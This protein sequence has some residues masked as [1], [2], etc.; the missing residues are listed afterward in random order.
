MKKF[1]VILALILSVN[2]IALATFSDMPENKMYKT[3]I[4]GLVEK[5]VLNGYDDGTF[6]P[7][8]H[9]T[10]AE[11]VKMIVTATN[12]KGSKENTFADVA[13]DYWAREFINIAVKNKFVEGYE[14]NTF[15][16]EDEI[17]YGEVVTVV[18]RALASQTKL[19][20]S[21]SWPMNYMKAAED[22]NLFNGYYTNDLV[23]VNPARRDNTA[24]ILWNA[25]N[26][27]TKEDNTDEIDTKT[28]YAGIVKEVIERRGEMYVVTDDGEFKLYKESQTPKINSFVI[29]QFTS[30]KQMKIRKE[31]T[32][33]DVDTSFLTIENVDECIVK[34]QGKENLLD[35]ELD[36]YEI[37]GTKYKLGKYNY[38]ILTIA[39]DEIDSYELFKKDTLKLKKDDKIKFDEKLN[40]CYVI[41]E[42]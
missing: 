14:D 29:Y 3:A 33:N 11:F 41:R 16:P 23:A 2:T 7:A 5:G 18:I 15:R 28:A 38:F 21:L 6:A 27:K 22:L 40:V 35:F 24:L 31:I 9:I 37:D 1:L 36:N 13:N 20:S 32:L 39:D 42:A 34:I 8:N 25:L 12:A 17:T 19:D 30:T 10:R 26:I 4:E